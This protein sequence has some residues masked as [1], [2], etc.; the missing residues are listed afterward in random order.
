[1]PRNDA[2]HSS[3]THVCDTS[4]ARTQA[5]GDPPLEEDGLGNSEFNSRHPDWDGYDFVYKMMTVRELC[6]PITLSE[7]KENRG[8][9]LAPRGLVYLPTSIGDMSD[10]DEQ[11]LASCVDLE[12]L[13]SVAHV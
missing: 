13:M 12:E 4:S 2:P 11:K 5:P 8:F 7:M 10:L 6:Q 3:I 1:M 9:K